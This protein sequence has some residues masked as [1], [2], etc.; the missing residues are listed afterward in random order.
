M[1]RL[2]PFNGMRYAHKAIRA[3]AQAM[4]GMGEELGSLSDGVAGKLRERFALFTAIMRG[5]WNGEEEILW[6]ALEAKV[7]Q[8]TVPYTLDHD[9]E[10]EVFKTIDD[11]LSTY[12]AAQ[13]ADERG[14]VAR[15]L[16]RELIA[17]NTAIAN[18]S[19]K[20]DK[21][22]IPLVEERFS[23]HEQEALAGAMVAHLPQHLMG[24]ITALVMRALDD[25]EREDFLRIMMAKMPPQAFRAT[26]RA[27]Q[28]GISPEAWSA[29]A[30]RVPEVREAAA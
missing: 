19:R 4:E 21:Q 24:E 6:P 27:V 17:L 2:A 1:N 13:S 14:A 9:V 28:A 20:E 22:I 5:H 3:E 23:P 15:R 18:H 25:D 7:P 10:I 8:V 30:L 26:A 16:Y 29:L 12:R 11:L